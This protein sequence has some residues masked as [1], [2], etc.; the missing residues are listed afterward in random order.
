MAT[1][2]PV[3][4][5][6]GDRPDMELIK[7]D[8]KDFRHNYF[9]MMS[10]CHYEINDKDL[11]KEAVKYI[12]KNTTY[13]STLLA[14][15]KDY[16]F[17]VFGKLCYVLNR[18]GDLI[19]EAYKHIEPF[20]LN[21]MILGE[22]EIAEKIE[23]TDT[24]ET[25]KV[26]SVQDHMRNAASEVAKEFDGWVD[27]FMENPKTFKIDECDPNTP[28]TIANLKAGHAR[29]IIMFYQDT[30]AEIEQA[31]AGDDEE[32]KE[33]YSTY[34]KPQLKT[35]CKLYEK[36]INAAKL[37]QASAKATRAPKAKKAPSHE[38]LVSKLS[39]KAQDTTL[40]IASINPVQIIEAKELWVY[41]TK[42]RKLGKYIAF[43]SVGL[44]VKGKS[45]TNFAELS[46]EKTLRKPAE[47][48]KEFKTA[49]K[50]KLRTFMDDIPTIHT[51][52]TGRLSEH[53]LL[54]RVVT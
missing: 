45:I 53:T 14:T 4:N 47:Q 2:K 48:L 9:N 29:F 3:K 1:R 26:V 15:V 54:L 35:L 39:Y 5:M 42:Y 51:K 25:K 19:E 33:A 31:I 38:K 20:I 36:I 49:N 10:Y 28:M 13:D 52:L 6:S 12:K 43:D 23:S 8:H 34:T 40:A 50:I 24:K 44:S 30:L 37:V 41:N 22:Q 11:K 27:S 17:A 7:K 32:L 46:I 16:H 21:L 18:G